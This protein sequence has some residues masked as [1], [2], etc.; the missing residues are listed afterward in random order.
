M[1]LGGPLRELPVSGRSQVYAPSAG[2]HTR[3]QI[4]QAALCAT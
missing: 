2:G 4:Q 1:Q 3:Y